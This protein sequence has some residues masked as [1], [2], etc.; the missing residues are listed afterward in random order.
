M[1]QRRVEM[2]VS[3]GKLDEFEAWTEKF[4]Q[5]RK[6]AGGFLGQ[7]LLRSYSTPSNYT[8]M[9][10]WENED[11]A[12][13]YARSKQFKAFLAGNQVDGWSMKNPV[14]AYDSVLEVDGDGIGQGAAG[15]DCEVLGDMNL[16]R[17]PAS[18]PELE[19]RIREIGESLKKNASGFGSMRLRRSTGDPFKYLMV[20]IF[21]DRD[22]A[23]G[24]LNPAAM[25]AGTGAKRLPDILGGRID[26][27]TYRVVARVAA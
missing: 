24:A 14:E 11:A 15:M 4:G 23:F 2:T 19:T 25:G 12:D 22:S 8:T 21:T 20:N 26:L 3:P 10:R 27:Q 18:V 6:M 7:S 1:Y 16:T 13:A 17:G 9:I 5:D